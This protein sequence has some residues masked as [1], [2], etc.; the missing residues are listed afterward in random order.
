MNY[1]YCQVQDAAR[2]FDLSSPLRRA[3]AKHL[4]LVATAMHEIEWADSGDT[5]PGD[6]DEAA[7]AACLGPHAEL[8]QLIDEAKSAHAALGKALV[9]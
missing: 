5:S 8:A 1:A 9:R 6:H 4:L 2:Q 7:I 3:F